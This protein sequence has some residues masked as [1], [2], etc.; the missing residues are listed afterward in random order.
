MKFD[1]M[2]HLTMSYEEI[3]RIPLEELRWYYEKLKQEKT[4][5]AETENTKL[6]LMVK[7]MTVS[8]GGGSPQSP[9]LDGGGRAPGGKPGRE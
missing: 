4:D 2:Y 7:A 1:L 6:E 9:Y 5:E 8:R 3:H